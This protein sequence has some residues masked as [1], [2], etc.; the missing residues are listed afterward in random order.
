MKDSS[1][2]ELSTQF[3]SDYI[4]KEIP[5]GVDLHVGKCYTLANGYN[6]GEVVKAKI[7]S[8]RNINEV[9]II[10]YKYAREIKFFGLF[11]TW[12]HTSATLPTFKAQLL[13]YGK[14]N[15]VRVVYKKNESI[16]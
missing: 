7:V 11:K 5:T 9:L 2:K 4:I 1:T 14:I 6:D 12:R 13:D 8:I 16:N 15:K 3:A 10:N